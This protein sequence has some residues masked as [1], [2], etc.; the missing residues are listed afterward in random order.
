MFK[1]WRRDAEEAML[2]EA[3]QASLREAE[4]GSDP[5]GKDSQHD[6]LPPAIDKAVEKV[7]AFPYL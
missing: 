6:E 5:A 2:V 3:I 1:A 7:V 4:S